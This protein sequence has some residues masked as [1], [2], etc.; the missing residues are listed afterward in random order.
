[1]ESV[2]LGV[3]VTTDPAAV[4]VAPSRTRTTFPLAWAPVALRPRVTAT[5][6]FD[7]SVV[8]HLISVQASWVIFPLAAEAG[9]NGA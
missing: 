3:E 9:Y 6:T 2:E 4:V 5:G 8:A 7:G 1:V